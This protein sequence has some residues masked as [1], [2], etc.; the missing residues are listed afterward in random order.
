MIYLYFSAVKDRGMMGQGIFLGEAFLPLQEIQVRTENTIFCSIM[1][2]SRAG[3]Y[4]EVSSI[5][6]DQ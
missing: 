6:A 5:L 3:G 2:A 1:E 4:K